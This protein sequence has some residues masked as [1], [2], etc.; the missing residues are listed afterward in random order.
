MS[1]EHIPLK[2]TI[3][4]GQSLSPQNRLRTAILDQPNQIIAELC[5]RSLF[6]FMQEFWDAYSNDIFVPNWHINK[7]CTELELVAQRVANKEPKLYDLII[8]IPPG[9]TKTAM[10]SIFF[11]IWCWINWYWMKFITSSHSSPLS[12]ES[13]EYSRDI[14]RSDKFKQTFP[15]LTIKQDKDSKSNFR[16][17][18]KQRTAL[19][20]VLQLNQGGGRVSTSV[21]ARITG[22]HAHI[23]ILDDLIDPKRALSDAGILAANNHMDHTLSTRKTDKR[24]AVTILIMQR[25][26]QNDPTGHLLDKRKGKKIKLICLPGE[27]RNYR[28]Q[29]QPKEFEQ[30]YSKDDLLDSVRMD[31]GVLGDLEEDLGQYGYAGQIGQAPTPPEGGMFKVDHFTIIDTLPS[32]VNFVNTVRYWDKAG[33]QG[34]GAFTVGLKMS[35]LKNKKFIIH[36]VV[37]GQWSAEIRE[38]IIKE[39][40]E[41]DGTSVQ[42]Y[43]EQEPGSGGK[44]SA[45]ATITNLA[46]FSA[47]KDRPTGNKFFRA[48][49]FS[50]QVN[51]GNVMLLRGDWIFQFK[52][53]YR[54]FGPVATY[55]DQVDAGSGAWNKLIG[56]KRAGM[57]FNSKRR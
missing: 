36:D 3:F 44:E 33:T 5:R 21:D 35:V 17:V 22:F 51:N 9:T 54:N 40:A 50:V 20:N 2:R 29:L 55:K 45:E 39:T 11:P 28:K 19:S 10:V 7:I 12:L 24:V 18:Q 14:I 41:A 52:E 31:W 13:A 8:N 43:T 49:P 15:E 30:Y 37:R 53:E 47:H 23:L 32:P 48:D 38:N 57:L 1:A 27:I 46:G 34:G 26:S 25:L 6:Y 16:V 42:V 56:K 4:P